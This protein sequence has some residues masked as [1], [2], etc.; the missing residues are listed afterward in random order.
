ML[1]LFK[2]LGLNYTRPLVKCY[3]LAVVIAAALMHQ[4]PC[5]P[6][7][8]V[9]H[10][11]NQVTLFLFIRHFSFHLPGNEFTVDISLR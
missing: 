7:L 1:D 2:R 6:V 8:S 3:A 4:L 5:P 11:R 9:I 10:N